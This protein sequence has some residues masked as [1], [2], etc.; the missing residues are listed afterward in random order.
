MVHQLWRRKRR[1]VFSQG[2]H[3]GR[4]CGVAFLWNKRLATRISILNSDD[5]HERSVSVKL[6]SFGASDVVITCAY[7][8]CMRTKKELLLMPV[9]VSATMKTPSIIM[10]Y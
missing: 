2:A 5:Q 1:V 7:F 10:L 8:P 3:L 4:G 9:Q 6:R